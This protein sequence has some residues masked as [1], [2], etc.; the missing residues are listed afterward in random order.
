VEDHGRSAGQGKGYDVELMVCMA[1]TLVVYTRLRLRRGIDACNT[2]WQACRE[3]FSM[4]CL[5]S[6]DSKLLHV[7]HM[8]S[9][10]C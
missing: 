5:C 1:I 2:A 6:N 7:S 3:V 10:Y 8:V 9:S 4:L